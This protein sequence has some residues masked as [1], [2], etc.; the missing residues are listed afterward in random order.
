MGN[1]TK[2]FD[3]S[4]YQCRCGCDMPNE[5]YLN[6]VKLA[7]QLQVLRDKIGKPVKLTNAY[8]CKEHNDTIAGSSRNSQH[9][10]GKA[11]DIKVKGMTPKEVFDVVESLINE[12]EVL[13]GGLSDY[14]TFTHYDFRGKKAR[15]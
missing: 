2:N 11:A 1:L 3:L 10:L 5:V 6:I 4:E 15:W 7:N 9:I 14:N 13:Q 12:G 8:R